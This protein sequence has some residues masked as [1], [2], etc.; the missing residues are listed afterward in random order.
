MNN[1]A[2]ASA[3]LVTVVNEDQSLRFEDVCTS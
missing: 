3:L 1:V 2:G